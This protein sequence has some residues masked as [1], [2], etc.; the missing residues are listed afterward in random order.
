M[1]VGLTSA[2]IVVVVVAT[3][4][5]G[6][7]G[8]RL[9]RTTSDF[10][11]ASRTVSTAWNAS[12][13]SGEYLSAASFL[14]VAGLVMTYGVD[15]LWY[16]VGFVAGYLVLLLLVAAP[17]RRSGAY[18]LADFAETR[19]GSR[20]TRRLAGLLVVA[21]AWLYILP[22]LQGAG[23]TL[24]TVTGAPQWAGAVIVTG[25]VVGNVLGGGMRSITFVQAFQYW[26]KMFAVAVPALVLLA[27][28]HHDGSASL[29]STGFP[30]FREATA[31]H[32]QTAVRLDVTARQTVIVHGVVDDRR[33]DGA[34]VLNAGE[35]DVGKGTTLDFPAGAAVPQADGLPRTTGAVWATPFGGDR[36]NHPLYR[37]YSLIF[38]TFLG[39]MGLPHVLVRFYT[40]PDGRAARR[41]TVVVIGL[42]GAFYLFPAIFGALGRLYTPQL[43]VTGQTDAVVLLLPG[44][45]IGGLA[46]Q[47]FGAV[48]A[49]GAFAAFLSTSSGLVVSVAGVV[50][51][52]LLGGT[53]RSFRQGTLL[54]GAVPLGLTFAATQLPVS[55]VVAMAF[56]VA[57]SSFCPLL[58]LG[59]WWRGLTAP[60]AT[61]GLL[62]GGGAAVVAVSLRIAGYAPP[63]WP[64]ALLAQPAA[65]TVPLAFATMVSVSLLSKQ[66]APADVTSVMMRMHAPELG[67]G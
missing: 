26:L 1:N 16:P 43:L 56:A 25:V 14:G 53:V 45:A 57:A 48:V 20:S 15:M 39:T 7:W 23:L 67:A 31:V 37:I 22:Q 30:T 58:L 18:T 2:A 13:I 3:C 49:A 6:L 52:D 19:L 66:R 10:M 55:E 54:A 44:A 11:V 32:I 8:M 50:A 40:N 65:V 61:A 47:V 17:L 38:A 33:R 28:W 63:G 4:A 46:G 62:V 12:A 36:D 51:Q 29:A 24:R 9:S 34:V 42:L 35:H 27:I 59:I 64:S 5:I 41:T 21:I 60:G